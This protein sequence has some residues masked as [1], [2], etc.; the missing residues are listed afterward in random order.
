MEDVLVCV[1]CG[2]PWEPTVKNVCECGALCSWGYEKGGNP[3]SWDVTPD[4]KWNPKPPP[5]EK[6]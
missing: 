5:K 3:L 1:I 4:G 6:L 2:E